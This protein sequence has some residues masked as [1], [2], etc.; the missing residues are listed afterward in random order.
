MRRPSIADGLWLQ[1]LQESQM[2]L[3]RVVADAGLLALLLLGLLLA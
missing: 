2:P 3:H 1:K